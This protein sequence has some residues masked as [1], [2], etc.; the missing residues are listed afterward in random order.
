MA[1][2]EVLDFEALLAPISD[3][4]PTGVWL[5]ADPSLNTLYFQVK[6][7]ADAARSAERQIREAP[8]DEEGKLDASIEPP[9]WNAVLVAAR[10]ALAEKTKDLWIVAWLIEA[11][12]RKHG[13][14]GLRD[15]FRL[16]RELCER[17]WGQLHP[18]ADEDDLEEGEL[19]TVMQLAGLNGIEAEGT[20]IVPINSIP[21]T[22][23]NN[24]GGLTS[25]D[26]TQAS[27]LQQVTDPEVRQR[28][29]EQGAVSMEMFDSAVHET[30]PDF[31]RNLFEDIDACLDEFATMSQVLDEKSGEHNGYQLSPPTSSIRNVIEDTRERLKGMTRSIFGDGEVGGAESH[32]EAG[33]AGGGGPVAATGNVQTRDAALREILKI[34]DFFEKTEPHS[35]MSYTLR[36]VVRW[37]RMSLPNLLA[38][39]LDDGTVRADLF[40]RTGIPEPSEP[41]S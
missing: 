41:E 3:E 30:S 16:T 9:D 24:Y 15:G 6:D 36:Q 25:A 38:E 2:P 20:L 27:E 8:R 14:A 40:R 23:S 22:D 10:K 31:F 4:S 26:Y 13:F 28:R 34:A 1:S 11:L 7:A 32:A 21:I 37:G 33:A 29:I 18:P 19:T 39:L 5:K 17:Y 12:C 35:P